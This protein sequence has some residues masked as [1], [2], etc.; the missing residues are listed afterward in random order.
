[1][2]EAMCK[3]LDLPKE[4]KDKI[5]IAA[6]L[7]DIGK[8]GIPDGVLMKSGKLNNQEYELIK[9]HAKIGWEVLREIEGAKD[10]SLCVKYHHERPDG[11]GYPNGLIQG[12][13]PI[14]ASIIAVADSYD[15]MTSKR[16]YKTNIEP[17]DALS[18]IVS[19][20]GIQFEEFAVDA[21]VKAF[22]KGNIKELEKC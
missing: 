5:H 11:K 7:H 8:I 17:E 16:V 13:I 18:E 14:G 9:N 2:V 19:L 20:K 12:Q 21:F 22:K 10:I 4:T 3:E 15:A 1:M 6:H